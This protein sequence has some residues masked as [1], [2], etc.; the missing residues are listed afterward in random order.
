MD[1]FTK[2]QALFYTSE[3]D[4]CHNYVVQLVCFLQ[5]LYHCL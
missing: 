5:L 3:A 2:I 4:P 1:C